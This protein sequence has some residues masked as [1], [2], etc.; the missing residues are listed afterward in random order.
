MLSGFYRK[1]LLKEIEVNDELIKIA[2]SIKNMNVDGPEPI[3]MK[4][5]EE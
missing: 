1:Q 4:I 5:A 3:K 2:R